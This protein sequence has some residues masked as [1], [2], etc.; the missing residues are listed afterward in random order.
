[1]F[2]LENIG[3]SVSNYAYHGQALLSIKATA[4]DEVAD[5]YLF[6]RKSKLFDD[7]TEI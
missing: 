7:F 6:D 4:A 5:L 1:M 2:R 3:E